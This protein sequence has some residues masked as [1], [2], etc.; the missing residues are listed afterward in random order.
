MRKNSKGNVVS[1]PRE[2][3]REKEKEREGS[4]AP[5][6]GLGRAVVMY[7]EGPAETVNIVRASGEGPFL[8]KG[9][10]SLWLTG[11]EAALR[12]PPHPP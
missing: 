4:A 8:M 7:T 2:R 10:G 3:E 12:A 11:G 6:A 1:T 9:G 5:T